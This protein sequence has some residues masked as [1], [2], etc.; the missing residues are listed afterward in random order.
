MA[1][2]SIISNDFKLDIIMEQLKQKTEII[3]V[4]KYLDKLPDDIYL[5]IENI[6][7]IIKFLVPGVDEIV[8]G[9]ILTYRY[10]G[11]LVGLGLDNNQCSFFL[12]SSTIIKDLEKDLEGFDT[13]N[14]IIRF[15]PEKPISNDLITRIV[16]AR[17]AENELK[18]ISK[19]KK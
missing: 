19:K 8:S 15:T 13:T 10:N 11:M 6:R 9:N 1:Y 14:D 12:M 18:R 17:M 16:M 5:P 2:Q 7:Q 4:D 3:T